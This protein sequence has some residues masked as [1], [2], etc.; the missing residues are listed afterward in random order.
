MNQKV[1]VHAYGAETEPINTAIGLVVDFARKNPGCH[2]VA[3]YLYSQHQMHDA[4][5]LSTVLGP[6]RCKAL[7]AGQAV[8]LP[9]CSACMRLMTERTV[10]KGALP[11]AVLAIYANDER[12]EK[13]ERRG[14]LLLTVAVPWGPIATLQKW[15]AKWKPVEFG[16]ARAVEG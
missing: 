8:A 2:D 13:I 6:V 11:D 16:A 12:L 9:D 5:S 4:T 15:I 10:A 14:D 1:L 3:L 7:L